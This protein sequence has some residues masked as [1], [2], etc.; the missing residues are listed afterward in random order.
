MFDKLYFSQDTSDMYR[1]NIVRQRFQS[2]KLNH[3]IVTWFNCAKTE[4]RTA[5]FHNI[6]LQ[7][8][9]LN[10]QVLRH[11]AASYYKLELVRGANPLKG[12]HLP[13]GGKLAV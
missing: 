11:T 8:V 1:F 4:Y 9:Y 12:Q 3:V 5:A 6:V 13:S 7:V 2:N 10:L